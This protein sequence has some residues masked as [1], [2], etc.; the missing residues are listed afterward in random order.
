LDG[1]RLLRSLVKIFASGVAMYAVAR[2]GLWIMGAGAE[3]TDSA[4]VLIFVGGAA[5]AA[6]VGAALLLKT[7]ELSSATSLLRGRLIGNAK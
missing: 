7:E 2:G 4:V 5:L 3:F 6:Y 1:R